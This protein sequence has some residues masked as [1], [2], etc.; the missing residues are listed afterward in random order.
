M[1]TSVRSAHGVPRATRWFQHRWPWLLMLGPAI[2]VVAGSY[3]SYLAYSQADALVVGDYYKQG[4]AINQDLR[5]DRIAAALGVT[6]T[7]RY[8][9][10]QGVLSGQLVHRAGGAGET[11][12]LH[13]AHATM[14]QKDIRLAAVPD[15]QGAF[16]V[17]LPMLVHSRYQV[18]IE[19]A[20]REWRLERSWRW[21]AQRELALTADAPSAQ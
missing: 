9:A 20:K 2:V 7:L 5:R 13:L 1:Q 12:M 14:P 10:M 11:L 16:S 4:K 17:G 3:T 15:A 21:P 8:D 18:L 6:V 19:N